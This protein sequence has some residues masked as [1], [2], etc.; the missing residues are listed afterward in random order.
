MLGR[1]EPHLF[2]RVWR[3]EEH[4]GSCPSTW[5]WEVTL[6]STV[7]EGGRH[8]SLPGAETSEPPETISPSQEGVTCLHNNLTL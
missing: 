2:F 4:T 7:R 5:S 3:L 1:T 8:A 6:V